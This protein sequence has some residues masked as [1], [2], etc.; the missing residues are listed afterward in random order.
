MQLALM[1]HWFLLYHLIHY[2]SKLIISKWLFPHR[3]HLWLQPENNAIWLQS[4]RSCLFKWKN[5]RE[6]VLRLINV[7]VTNWAATG[8][9]ESAYKMWSCGFCLGWNSEKK[10][11]SHWKLRCCSCQHWAEVKKNLKPKKRQKQNG[12]QGKNYKLRWHIARTTASSHLLDSF[13]AAISIATVSLLARLAM[14]L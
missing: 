13:Y 9:G 12:H 8:S 11:L 14:Q 6:E 1:I 10:L 3:D 5:T 7:L 2:F 4:G